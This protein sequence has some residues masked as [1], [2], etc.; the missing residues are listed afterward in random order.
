MTAAPARLQ[1]PIVPQH[2]TPP[3]NFFQVLDIPVV[4]ASNVPDAP[5]RVGETYAAFQ[6]EPHTSSTSV[7]VQLLWIAE[8]AIYQV[9]GEGETRVW[10]TYADALLDLLNRL[11]HAILQRFLVRGI[12]AIH[13]GALS[14]QGKA[15]II[16]GRSGQGK[17]TLVLGLVRRGLGLLSDEFA[18]IEPNGLI[19]PYRRSLHIRPGTPELIPELHFLNERPRHQLGGGIEWALTPSD[20]EQ[21]IPGCLG[22]AALPRHLLLLEGQPQHEA[23]PKITPLPAAVATIELVRGT[24]AASVDFSRGLERIGRML[25]DVRCARLQAGRLDRTIDCILEWLQGSND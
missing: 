10:S 17:T 24:W 7:E 18:I 15:L 11:V 20:L 2:T 22:H 5:L 9:T 21:A 12:Y 1:E 14:H 23:Q 4:V 19:V 8:Q 6:S 13:A 16:S 3:N 25:T